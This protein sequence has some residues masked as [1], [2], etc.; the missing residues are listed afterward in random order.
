MSEHE[1][2][3]QQPTGFL[4]NPAKTNFLLG[5][6]IGLATVSTIG[7]FV[8]L[9]MTV[10]G[11]G[12]TKSVAGAQVANTNSGTNTNTAAAP[13]PSAANPT[14]TVTVAPTVEEGDHI[15][16]NP[17]A[18]VTIVE[19]SDFQCP[20]CGQ[21]HPTMTQLFAEYGTD[22]RWVYKHF[23]LEN[24]H[25]Q[26]RPAALASECADEQ[27]KFWEFADQLFEN[28]SQLGPAY[29][30]QLAG[31]L[32]LNV[33]QFSACV[34]DEKYADH[35][36]GDYQ[37]GVTVGVTGTPGTVIGDQLIPGA[38]SLTTLKGVVDQQL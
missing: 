20:Y 24:I 4:A 21:F 7:F 14:G 2:S 32:G 15:R 16:G 37:E 25:P 8:L 9:G 3:H 35:V 29:F 30:E 27:G 28:Q 33:E 1:H 19:Y 26:A 12:G 5:F 22:V 11:D 17:D 36:D 10:N 31:D 13:T 18:P 6:F 23:P 34:A 38:V